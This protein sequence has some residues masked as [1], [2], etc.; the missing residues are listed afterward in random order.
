MKANARTEVE[1]K[2]LIAKLKKRKN[3]LKKKFTIKFN[4]NMFQKIKA[5]T[6]R[7]LLANLSKLRNLDE[8]T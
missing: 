5:K 3:Q 4:E 1:R 8:K 2:K 7:E 6:K